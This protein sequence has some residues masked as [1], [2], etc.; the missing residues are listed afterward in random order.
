MWQAGQVVVVYIRIGLTPERGPSLL[1]QCALLRFLQVTIAV[2]LTIAVALVFWG[3]MDNDEFQHLHLAWQVARGKALYRELY[4]SH[5]PLYTLLNSLA[6]SVLQLSPGAYLYSLFRFTSLMYL[7]GICVCLYF[8]SQQI[9]GDRVVSL[10]SC[11]IFLSLG[12]TLQSGLEIR[13]DVMQNLFWIGSVL[14]L[15]TDLEGQHPRKYFVAGILL[16]AACVV[17]LKAGICAVAVGAFF[18]GNYVFGVHQH[19]SVL[20]RS[21]YSFLVGALVV[22]ILTTVGFYAWGSLDELVQ[23]PIKYTFI[24]LD[25]HDIVGNRTWSNVRF[26]LWYQKSFVLLLVIGTVLIARM[27]KNRSIWFLITLS[28]ITTCAIFTGTFKQIFLIFLPLLSIVAAKGLATTLH[29]VHSRWLQGVMLLAVFLPLLAVHLGGLDGNSIRKRARQNALTER[30]VLT[31]RRDEPLAVFWNACGGYSFNADHQFLWTGNY[32]HWKSLQDLIRSR[33]SPR[34]FGDEFI[35]NLEDK[36]V[37]YIIG[38]KVKHFEPD[39]L[40]YIRDHF[41]QDGCLWTKKS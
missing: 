28:G 27:T 1:S 8:L 38:D 21:Y 19:R 23:Y 22:F 10:A 3:S 2:S 32:L 12:F 33:S 25:N 37:R 24:M 4:D 41:S 18:V 9:L 15:S 35:K 29:F 6:F 34:S 5:G 16:A 11:A 36:K 13:P 14:L 26:F 17:N 31:T 20:Y 7:G 39:Q 40:Q 30:I